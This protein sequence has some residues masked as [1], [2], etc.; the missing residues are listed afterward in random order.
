M[1]ARL[2]KSEMKIILQITMRNKMRTKNMKMVQRKTKENKSI[3]VNKAH[4]CLLIV[5]VQ[6]ISLKYI[7]IKKAQAMLLVNLNN[8]NQ[9]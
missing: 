6:Q 7:L 1:K 5:K 8:S 4:K 3:K 9:S 2:M